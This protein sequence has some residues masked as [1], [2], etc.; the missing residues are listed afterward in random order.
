MPLAALVSK[1]DL[2]VMSGEFWK[3]VFPA[4]ALQSD[5]LALLFI[6]PLSCEGRFNFLQ[7]ADNFNN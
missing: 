2:S 1:F 7:L 4:A 3:T 5:T 6:V